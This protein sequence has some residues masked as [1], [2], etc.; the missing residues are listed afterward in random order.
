MWTALPPARAEETAQNLV[1]AVRAAVEAPLST[2]A[3]MSGMVG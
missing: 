2:G 1:A 3:D